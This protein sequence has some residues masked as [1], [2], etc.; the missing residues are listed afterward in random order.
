MRY[1]RTI[2]AIA[3]GSGAGVTL[4]SLAS[5]YFVEPALL[6]SLTPFIVVPAALVPLV[7]LLVYL[8]RLFFRIRD[9][10]R[11]RHF[12]VA[13][14]AISLMP[15]NPLLPTGF[16]AFVLRMANVP[17]RDFHRLAVDL[18]AYLES[19]NLSGTRAILADQDEVHAALREA[20]PLLEVSSWKPRLNV[21]RGDVSILWGSGLT[22]GYEAT[23][24]VEAEQPRWWDESESPKARLYERV[25][26]TVL[27]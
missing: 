1:H 16:D 23:V 18:H 9:L 17:S 25:F 13:L 19:Q 21:Q 5:G 14:L 4:T 22:G 10:Q 2:L 8:L 15:F 20:H 7:V 6:G 27:N 11:W 12:A 26:L 24:S 3:L